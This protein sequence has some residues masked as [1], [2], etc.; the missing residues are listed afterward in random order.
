MFIPS[1]KVHNEYGTFDSEPEWW[2]FEQKILPRMKNGEIVN[3]SL[4]DTFTIIPPLKKTV[5]IQLKTKVKYVERSVEQ[6]AEYTCDFTY[7]VET[8]HGLQ[9]HVVEYKSNYSAKARDYSLRR[10]LIR[11]LLAEWN[12][13][14]GWEKYVFDEYR[15]KDLE[16]PPK[17]PRK[18]R[19]PKQPK[20]SVV[21]EF[22]VDIKTSKMTIKK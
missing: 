22:A 15:E 20:K 13:T 11:R 9:H 10:K 5:A 8:E 17:K 4:H 14:A 2:C 16:T 18:K 12:E 6:A 7:D 19:E 1:K 21:T 3:V